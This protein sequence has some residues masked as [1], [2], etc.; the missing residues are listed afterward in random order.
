MPIKKPEPVCRSSNKCKQLKH[1][2]ALTIIL[3]I[4]YAMIKFLPI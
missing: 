1:T 4:P 3:L 2:V